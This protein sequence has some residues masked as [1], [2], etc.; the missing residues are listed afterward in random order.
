L[1]AILRCDQGAEMI[2]NIVAACAVALS[3]ASAAA[4]A[5]ERLMRIV[6]A[7]PPGGPV[8]FV[9]RVIADPLGR[10]LNLRVIVENKPGGNGVVAAQSV[11]Q[12]AADGTALWLTSVGAAAINP[13]LYEKL[14]YDMQRDFAAVSLVVDNDELLVVNPSNPAR[15]AAEFVENARKSSQPVAIASS[16]VGSIPHLAMEQ[17]ADATRANLL[18]VP[19][20]GAAPAITDVIGGQVAAFFGDVP[21]LI[22]H[23]R[24]GKLKAIG[25]AAAKRHPLLPAVRTLAEQGLPG[26]DT[27]NWYALFV[28]AKT[29]PPVIDALN[30]A[31]RRTLAL[32]AVSEKL[33]ASGTTPAPSTQQELSA[34]LKRDT[35]KWG[36]LIRAKRISPEG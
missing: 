22:G 33:L 30:E 6:V 10:E 31:M 23:V 14:P 35:E 18:H 9:A 2:R 16:G 17:L 28:P 13:V 29:P 27:S 32:P 25:I 34:L 1:K 19:Y 11:A 5:Q 8:D 36:R 15:D 21:G 3:L 12:A 24:S 7:F 4:G 20:K 26:V